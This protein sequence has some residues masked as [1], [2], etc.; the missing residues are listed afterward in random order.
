MLRHIHVHVLT[1]HIHV[2]N[3][4]EWGGL[5]SA[6]LAAFWKNL[7]RVRDIT[8]NFFRLI[9]YMY[10][11]YMYTCS[12][13][14]DSLTGYY[15]YVMWVNDYINQSWGQMR[16]ATPTYYFADWTLNWR[17]VCLWISLLFFFALFCPH[18]MCTCVTKHKVWFCERM[19]KTLKKLREKLLCQLFNSLC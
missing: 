16:V 4:L 13:I 8:R 6:G 19:L 15:M 3:Y 1:A 11:I 18:F 5:T 14:T 10:C 17:S 9:S 7:S 2:W 12:S